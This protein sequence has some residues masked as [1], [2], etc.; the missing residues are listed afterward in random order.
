MGL[1]G[2]EFYEEPSEI[3]AI[4][5]RAQL[6]RILSSSIFRNSIQQGR[7]LQFIVERTLSE[8]HA[9]LKE[10][11]VGIEVFR[12]KDSFDPRV[13]PIVRVEAGRLRLRLK[14]YYETEGKSDQLI[15]E[16]PKGTYGPIFHYR[17]SCVA[18]SDDPV[19]VQDSP[20]SSTCVLVLPFADHSPNFDQEWFCDGM[21]E[22][23]INALSKVPYLRLVASPSALRLKGKEHDLQELGRQ[24]GT[25]TVVRGGVRKDGEHLRITVQ[26][27]NLADNC[28]LWSESYDRRLEDVFAVQ[29]EIASAIVDVL[30]VRLA[31]ESY[32]LP[33]GRHPA[34]LKAYDRYL[35]GRHYWNK[36]TEEG[37][38]K[39]IDSFQQAV[40]ENAEYALA[41]CGL[42]DSYTL[43]ENYGA[44]LPSVV[45]EK[46]KAAA[47]RAVKINSSLAEAHTSLGHVMATYDHDWEGGEREYKI[48]LSLNHAYATAHHWYA[49]TVLA[50]LSRLEEAM[51]EILLAQELDPISLSINRDVGVI[52][53]YRREYDVVVEQCRKT[54]ALDSDFYGAYWLLGLAYEQTGMHH[55]AASAFQKGYELSGGSPRLLGALGHAYALWGKKQ[56]AL[57]AMKELS[58]LAQERYVT[59]FETASIYLGLG[60]R[61][62]FLEFL[63]KAYDDRSFDCLFLRVDPRFDL[64][65][66]D[67]RFT[68]LL[69]NLGLQSRAC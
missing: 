35:R 51:S 29:E 42:A 60:D 46:A 23:L 21:T 20:M 36:R 64:L 44:A 39:G 41:Y 40:A 12:R 63:R 18:A 16:L 9:Q 38:R 58:S 10:Y 11:V 50:P 26:L 2:Q 25:G 62:K 14:Q 57:E 61:E 28:Y 6:K 27:I 31:R 15:I 47:M 1:S 3:S 52:L 45:R 49:V 48:A 8:H 30:C 68:C 5:V 24:L 69:S 17:R 59:P 54:L 65:R 33:S 22:E 19:T 34:S 53:Y 55:E 66:T 4:E 7:F 32:A 13:D 67:E 37:L 43:L 56:Q